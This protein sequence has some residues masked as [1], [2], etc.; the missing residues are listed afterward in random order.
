MRRRA[1]ITLLG[2]AAVRRRMNL[3]DTADDDALGK[4][5]R[6]TTWRRRPATS[7]SSRAPEAERPAACSGLGHGCT[8]ASRRAARFAR[9]RSR[10]LR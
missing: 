9:M 3:H 10:F 8:F 1:F 5:T 4:Q 7:P 2:G 6:S